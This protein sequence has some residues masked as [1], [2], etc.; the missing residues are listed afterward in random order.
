MKKL[1]LFLFLTAGVHGF[2]CVDNYLQSNNTL[3]HYSSHLDRSLCFVSA[4][5][6]CTDKQTFVETELFVCYADKNNKC[7]THTAI[8]TCYNHRITT[9]PM[10]IQTVN[11]EAGQVY[12]PLDG[13][14]NYS[15]DQETRVVNFSRDYRISFSHV[16]KTFS[17]VADLFR[18][19]LVV[20]SD[21]S[22]D[23]I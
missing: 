2:A 20:V 13:V 9:F 3:L 22:V 12:A 15:E 21:I 14:Y 4:T 8:Q 23:E 7:P 1:V 19:P 16:I 6:R 18:A 17:S 11:I 5:K 10:S